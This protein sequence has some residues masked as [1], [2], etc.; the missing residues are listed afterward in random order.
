MLTGLRDA[1]RRVPLTGARYFNANVDFRKKNL[2]QKVAV[3][4]SD[5]NFVAVIGHNEVK[6]R[7]VTLEGRKFPPR[8]VSLDDLRDLFIKLEDLYI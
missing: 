3:G 7:T 4:L 1:D 5:Y 8:E 2:S 6:N